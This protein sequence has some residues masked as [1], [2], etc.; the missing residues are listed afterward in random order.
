MEDVCFH[1]LIL[2][3]LKTSSN[4]LELL[5]IFDPYLFP[6]LPTDMGHSF[7]LCDVGN[8]SRA[9]ILPLDSCPKETLNGDK[10]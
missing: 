3:Y 8:F 2:S 10:V 1:A 4:Y 9:V 7:I 5:V 6:S